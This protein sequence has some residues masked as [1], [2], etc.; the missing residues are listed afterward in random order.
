MPV[1]HFKWGTW[2]VICDRCGFKY[3]NTELREE[4]HTKL[5]VCRPCLDKRNPQDFMRP[6][7]VEGIIPWSRPEPTDIVLDSSV[8]CDLLTYTWRDFPG[9]HVSEDT[10]ILKARSTGP[11]FIED[12]VTVTITC[13]WEIR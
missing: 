1:N 10:T 8:D 9:N 7:R 2:W 11:I 5:M 12:G 6:P 4:Q 3:K 13:T